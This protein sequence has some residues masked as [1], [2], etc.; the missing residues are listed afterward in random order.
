MKVTLKY[1]SPIPAPISKGDKIGVLEVKIPYQETIKMDVIAGQSVKQLG[2]L[3]RLVALFTS[4][5]W[6]VSG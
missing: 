1:K 3:G 2:F 5:I 4:V 6:G